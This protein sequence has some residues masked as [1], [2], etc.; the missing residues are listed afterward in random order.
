MSVVAVVAVVAVVVVPYIVLFD[1][2][3]ILHMYIGIVI[4]MC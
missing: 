4:L 2:P 3:V 1:I